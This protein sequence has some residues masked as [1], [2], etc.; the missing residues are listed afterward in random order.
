[1]TKPNK[2]NGMMNDFCVKK[3][4]CGG[5][6]DG[7][8]LHVSQFIPKEG[9]VSADQFVTWLMTAEGVDPSDI[10]VRKELIS[11]FMKHMGN[12]KVE[13]RRLKSNWK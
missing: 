5:V 13:A 4:W 7:K 8:P 2:Y 10:G 11:V 6:V 1:M 12:Y 9:V 3:G